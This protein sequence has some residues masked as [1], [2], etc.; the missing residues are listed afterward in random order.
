M[1]FAGQAVAAA[2]GYAVFRQIGNQHVSA[3][4]AVAQEL[5]TVRPS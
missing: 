2:L 5:I 4:A 3:C 1:P